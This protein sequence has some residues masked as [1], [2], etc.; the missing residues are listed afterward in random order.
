MDLIRHLRFFVTVADE[1]H[2]GRAAATLDMTQPPLSQGLRKLEQHLG[3]ELVHRTRQGAVLTPAGA[4]LLPRARLLVDDADRFL[5]EAGRVARS[6]GLLH[7][8]ATHALPCRLVTLCVAAL[9][10]HG[11]ATVSTRS[12][13][14]VELVEAVRS[15]MC[16]LAVVEHPALTEGLEAGPVVKLRR[17]V[18][19]PSDHRSAHSDRPRLPM[20]SDLTF[21][22]PPRTGNPASFDAVQ[23][24]LRERGLDVDTS[25]ATDDRA[26]LAAVA[27]GTHFGIS[28]SPPGSAPGVAWL[29]WAPPALALRVRIVWRPGTGADRHVAAL[30]RVLF[31]ERI[32]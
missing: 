3:A 5:A 28:T 9:R 20:L 19:V 10:G 11:E 31:K 29:D 15:G 24:L 6:R 16:D 1:R 21:A 13:T 2:F 23:D 26:V 18:L 25:P 30:D 22:A 4:E 12:A 17:W 32:R 14:T 27:A 8:G 7:W